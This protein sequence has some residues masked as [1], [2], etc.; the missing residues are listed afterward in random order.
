MNTDETDSMAIAQCSICTLTA[1]RTCKA[2]NF[3]IGLFVEALRV[4]L[5]KGDRQILAKRRQAFIQ[6]VKESKCS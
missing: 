4:N 6:Q 2:C 3:R 5:S 1:L